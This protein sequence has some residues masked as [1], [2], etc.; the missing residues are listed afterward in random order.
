MIND[1]ELQQLH[2]D[3]YEHLCIK[4]Y[5]ESVQNLSQNHYKNHVINRLISGIDSTGFVYHSV[6]D[7]FMNANTYKIFQLI[8]KNNKWCAYKLTLKTL[9]EHDD[10][11]YYHMNTAQLYCALYVL[12]VNDILN[13]C[14]CIDCMYVNLN[15]TESTE[16]AQHD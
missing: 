7:S 13:Y 15:N 11:Y 14:K 6:C 12:I 9:L 5:T 3:I 2:S 4:C 8:E 1:T 10:S 16:S